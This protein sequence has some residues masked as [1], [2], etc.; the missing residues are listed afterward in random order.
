[1]TQN[2]KLLR[3]CT[4][5]IFL[6]VTIGL[7]LCLNNAVSAREIGEMRCSRLYAP[8]CGLKESNLRTYSNACLADVASALVLHAGKCIS[9]GRCPRIRILPVCGRSP[10]TGKE[11]TY[12]NLCWA[13]KDWAIFVHKGPCG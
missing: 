5:T 8:V 3:E 12:D 2:R 6:V 1:M 9:H 10:S 4:E 7:A 13:E 11:K